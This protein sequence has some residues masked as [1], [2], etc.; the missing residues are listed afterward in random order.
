MLNCNFFVVQDLT[1]LGVGMATAH[2]SRHPQVAQYCSVSRVPSIVGVVSGRV[3][4]F[5]GWMYD[6]RNIKNFVKTILPALVITKVGVVYN[7]KVVG[8]FKS[9]AGIL[10]IRLVFFLNNAHHANL[11]LT[12]SNMEQ[13][14]ANAIPRNRPR[15]ILFSRSPTPSLVYHLTAFYLHG[16]LDFAHVPTVGGEL[17]RGV[18]RRFG[19]RVGEKKIMA[20][21]EDRNAILVQPVRGGTIIVVRIV[22]FGKGS[23]EISTTSVHKGHLYCWCKLLTSEVMTA[24]LQGQYQWKNR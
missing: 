24:S 21:K 9:S 4:H 11:Q 6:P 7:D 19:V 12:E 15:V 22:H 16:G 2:T 1:S 10:S 3:T 20:F 8:T 18:E 5:N 13:F 17:E 23:S 14:L